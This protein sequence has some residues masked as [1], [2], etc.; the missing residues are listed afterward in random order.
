MTAPQPSVR[1]VV[2]DELVADYDDRSR[3]LGIVACTPELAAQYAQESASI[4]AL[5]AT[6]EELEATAH[7]LLA[8]E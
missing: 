2:V 6:P 8:P 3:R 5:R 7:C 1:Q 4:L